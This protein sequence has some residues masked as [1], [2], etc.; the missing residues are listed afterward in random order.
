M[1]YTGAKTAKTIG[2]NDDDEA[3]GKFFS[4]DVIAKNRFRSLHQ[5]TYACCGPS[6]VSGADSKQTA[7]RFSNLRFL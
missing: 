6:Y 2:R 7:S 1:T 3:Y 5:G 4:D